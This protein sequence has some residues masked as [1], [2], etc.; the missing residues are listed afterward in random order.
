[1][2]IRFA[3]YCET[4]KDYLWNTYKQAMK[5]HIEKIWGWETK[6]QENDFE[7]NLFKYQTQILKFKNSKVGYI[8]L[9]KKSDNLFINML[10]LEPSWLSKGFGKSILEQ[11]MSSN[12]EKKIRLRCFKVNQ[13][14]YNFYQREGFVTIDSNDEFFELQKNIN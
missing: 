7:Q 11:L 6:W 3:P 10:I 5:P 1:M 14:A 2:K 12:P 13:S 9:E 8:Q 4:D